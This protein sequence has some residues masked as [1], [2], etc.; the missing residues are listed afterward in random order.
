MGII[1]QNKEEDREFDLVHAQR[2]LQWQD[3]NPQ[4]KDI[5]VIKEGELYTYTNG[6]LIGNASKDAGKGSKGKKVTEDQ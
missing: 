5:W 6:E 3:R 4:E 2:V 1:L